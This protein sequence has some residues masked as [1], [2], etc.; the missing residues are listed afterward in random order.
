MDKLMKSWSVAVIFSCIIL[1]VIS[2]R[3]IREGLIL[4]DRRDHIHAPSISSFI[5]PEF[6][7]IIDFLTDSFIFPVDVRLFFAVE[8]KVI[9]ATLFVVFPGTSAEA[10]TPVVWL[11]AICFRVF[12]DVIITVFVVF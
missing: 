5:H 10:G 12:P 9:L 11:T 4:G 6:H 7:Q 1:A 2:L 8:M 3:V